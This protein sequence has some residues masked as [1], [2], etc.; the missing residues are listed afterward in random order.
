[1]KITRTLKENTYKLLFWDMVQKTMTEDSYIDYDELKAEQ[2]E[3]QIAKALK[4]ANDSRKLVEVELISTVSNLWEWDV[5][6]IKRYGKIVKKP[7]Y[8]V[9]A[10]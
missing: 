5:A 6:D 3:K 7:E 10:Q 9:N 4:A 8:N 2:I 1:M